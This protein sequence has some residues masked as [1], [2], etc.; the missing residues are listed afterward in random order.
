MVYKKC[1]KEE[2]IIDHEVEEEEPDTYYR[3]GTGVNPRTYAK[4]LGANDIVTLLIKNDICVEE[5]VESEI[6]IDIDDQEENKL[7]GSEAEFGARQLGPQILL[8]EIRLLQRA[9]VDEDVENF[10]QHVREYS[11]E[12]YNSSIGQSEQLR[13]IEA[14]GKRPFSGEEDPPPSKQSRANSRRYVSSRQHE[15]PSIVGAA[16]SGIGMENS[17]PTSEASQGK[18]YNLESGRLT[19]KIF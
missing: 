1:Y 5:E 13:I 19:G 17:Q 8:N 16:R 4:D 11:E 6:D 10:F 2:S 7:V 18:I 9:K 3:V 15:D 14:L 12:K